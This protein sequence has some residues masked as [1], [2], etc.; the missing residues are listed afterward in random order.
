M[1]SA[2][3]DFGVIF[4]TKLG[5]EFGA[6]FLLP[7]KGI[8]DPLFGRVRITALSLIILKIEKQHSLLTLEEESPVVSACQF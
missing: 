4:G 3:F 8:P 2:Y 6:G 1:S 5:F 7:G